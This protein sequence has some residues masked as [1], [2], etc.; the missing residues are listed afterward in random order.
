MCGASR[1]ISAS[2][3]R[4][5]SPP[6]ILRDLHGRLVA[7]EA[8]AAELRAHRAGRRLGH[9]PAHM[10]ERRVLAV[11][12]LDLI[13]GEIADAQLAGRGHRAFHRRQLG[14]EQAGER[15]L[16]VAVAAEQGDAV[17]RVEAQVEAREDR[18]AGRVA[19]RGHV[20]RD[21]RRLQLGGARE[22]EAQARILGDRGDRLPS[23]R[24]P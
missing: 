7:G 24:A 22:I 23:G 16:A 15:G 11:Q 4:A 8:E 9:Q 14:G 5:R 3:S 21:Q 6:D 2:A 12:L 1:V 18:L 19:D 17:V 10:F 20:E 13:L